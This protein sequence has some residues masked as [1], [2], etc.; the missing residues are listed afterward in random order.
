MED[1]VENVFGS[2]DLF[3]VDDCDGDFF[4]VRPYC[5]CRVKGFYFSE[6]K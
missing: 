2:V 6:K 3:V 5:V 1:G 4:V